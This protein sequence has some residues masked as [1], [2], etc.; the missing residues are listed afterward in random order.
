MASVKLR[1]QRLSP[2]TTSS[3][4]DASC[5]RAASGYANGTAGEQPRS[6]LGKRWAWQQESP[7]A[8]QDGSSKPSQQLEL[9]AAANGVGAEQGSS[10]LP[11]PSDDS[12]SEEE[13]EEG[14]LAP[15]LQQEAA[16][17]GALAGE[18]IAP[19][20]A[21]AVAAAAGATAGEAAVEAAANMVRPSLP[22]LAQPDSSSGGG[23]SPPAQQQHQQRVSVQQ[24]R[25]SQRQQLLEQPLGQQQQQLEQQLGRELSV[26]LE[27]AQQPHQAARAAAHAAAPHPDSSVFRR[28]C[29]WALPGLPW[30]RRQR[31]RRV[32]QAVQRSASFAEGYRGPDAGEDGQGE[33]V[34]RPQSGRRT[35]GGDVPMQ[36]CR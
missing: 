17:A 34:W 25:L 7:S 36:R 4:R 16:V 33:D 12:S 14:A 15:Q 9:S 1:L 23:Q 26:D 28:C 21:A 20:E 30:H 32:S 19:D 29:P 11:L 18:G 6:C 5:I 27:A 31:Q 2:F 35:G 3:Q 24:Q 8:A 22:G 10:R 13:E